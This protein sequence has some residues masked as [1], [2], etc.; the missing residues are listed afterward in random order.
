MLNFTAPD[1]SS[2]IP[3]EANSI[4]VGVVT[5][6]SGN[7]VFVE[8]PQIAP[9]FSFGPCLVA[10]NDVQVSATTTVTKSGQGFVTSVQTT[11]TRQRIVPPV[12]SRVFCAFLNGSID[13]LAVL[14]SI[15]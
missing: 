13:E 11:V 4:Y 9:G 5:Q 10:A 6:V 2:S 14:G 12:G 8:V 7:R 15:L 3:L 1:K